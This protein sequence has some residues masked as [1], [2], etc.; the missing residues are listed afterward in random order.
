M[1]WMVVEV[2]AAIVLNVLLF[3]DT[4]GVSVREFVNLI[5]T[6]IKLLGRLKSYEV[7]FSGT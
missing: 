2:N 4:K 3:V 5:Y 7:A 6:R 1:V